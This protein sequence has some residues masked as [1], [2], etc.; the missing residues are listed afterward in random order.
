MMPRY[1][2]ETT[3]TIE[4]CVRILDGFM[5]AGAHYLLN[6][7]WGCEVDDHRGWMIVEAN[8]DHDARLMIPPVV[9]ASAVMIR[10][11]KFT[12][13]QVTRMVHEQARGT[14]SS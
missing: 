14:T 3:H 2:I 8:D 11:N 9:R 7:D 1:L 10:L 12:D 4:D 6:A 5:Q 13:E